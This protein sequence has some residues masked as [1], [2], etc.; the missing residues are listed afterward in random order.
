MLDEI[1]NDLA[2]NYNPEDD[3]LLQSIIDE[4]TSSALSISNRAD[5][6]E[7]VKS[8]YS[9]IKQCVKALYLQ[10]GAEGSTSFSGSGI[11]TSFSNA[12]EDL[13]KNIVNSGKRRIF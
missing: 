13:R 10:R 7:N 6:P 8:L 11:S 2:D 12:Y 4:V 9:E 5:T 3:D 1:R